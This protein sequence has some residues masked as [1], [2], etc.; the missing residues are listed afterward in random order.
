[1]CACVCACVGVCVCVCVLACIPRVACCL[2]L[3]CG[4]TVA[5]WYGIAAVSACI[6]LVA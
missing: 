5:L 2:Y 3:M 1:M 4:G 6:P